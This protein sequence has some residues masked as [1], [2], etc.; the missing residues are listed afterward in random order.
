MI[1]K[2]K[3]DEM[4]WQAE[5]SVW[6]RTAPILFPV[7]GK[8]F[9][10]ELLIDGKL[11]S[12]PQH[13]FARD[14]QFE[15]FEKSEKQIIFRLLSN[16][17]TLSIFPF[18]FDLRLGYTLAKNTVRC[19][20]EVKN[21]GN[22]TMYFS[23]GAHPGF[24]L[25]T[26]KL[27][28]YFIEFEQEENAERVLLSDGLVN[29]ETEHILNNNHILLLDHSL[30]QKDAIVFKN[31]RSKKI[32]LCSKISPFKIEM[33][34]DDFPFLGIWCKKDCESFI[35]LEPWCGIA[36]SIGEQIP[37]QQKEGINKLAPGE[38]MERNYSITF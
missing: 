3:G 28:N 16:E 11:Y 29:G 17:K 18:Y 35:C 9:N 7:V 23:I 26:Q 12:M 24:A 13:G 10:N 6:G 31:L 21:I 27:E 38:K 14:M 4:M 2:K 19:G 8:P 30:F 15:V 1:N 22:D 20:Y 32:I 36:G 33:T 37:V 34:W 5:G 25:P